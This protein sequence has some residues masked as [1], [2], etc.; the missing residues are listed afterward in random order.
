MANLRYLPALHLRPDHES[1]HR[2]F[3]VGG[4]LLA[5]RGVGV[6]G[7]RVLGNG[8]GAKL[9]PGAFADRQQQTFALH[10]YGRNVYARIHR[11]ILYCVRRLG[12]CACVFV[13]YM[14]HVRREECVFECVSPAVD[15]AFL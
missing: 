7:R 9:F 8:P 6:R 10:R 11:V 12:V 4:L 14:L 1:I 13:G 15:A 3:N 2:S 5:S